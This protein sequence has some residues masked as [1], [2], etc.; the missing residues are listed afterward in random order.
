MHTYP[1]AHTYTLTH[2]YYYFPLPIKFRIST[3]PQVARVV[4][5]VD[6]CGKLPGMVHSAIIVAAAVMRA[7]STT[8][9]MAEELSTGN[10]LRCDVFVDAIIRIDIVTRTRVLHLDDVELFDIE[11]FDSEGNQFSNLEGAAIHTLYT[12][13]HVLVCS[14]EWFFFQVYILNGKL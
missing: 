4:P 3:Q 14:L 9:V 5:V 1:H 6:P 11:A 12:P 8:L 2:N 13:L 7:R 10:L